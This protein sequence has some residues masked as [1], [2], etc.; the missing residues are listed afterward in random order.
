MNRFGTAERNSSRRVGLPRRVVWTVLASCAV[1]LLAFA[2]WGRG[3]KRHAPVAS[4]SAEEFFAG[5]S[6]PARSPASS[7]ALEQAQRRLLPY[8]VIPGGVESA[9][10]LKNAIANDPIVAAHYAGFNL[11]KARVQRLDRDRAV[12]VSYRLGNR[13]YWTSGKRMLFKGETV[14]TDGDHEART[15]CGN[16]ISETPA[17][18]VS[19]KEPAVEV[20]EFP[21]E[22]L[23]A[24]DLPPLDLP[25]AFPVTPAAPLPGPAVEEGFIPTSPILPVPVGFF[26]SSPRNPGGPGNSENPGNPVAPFYPL[27][28]SQQPP[29]STPEPDALLLAALGIATLLSGG[30]LASIRNRRERLLVSLP[31]R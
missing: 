1:M 5:Q 21:Q 9:A 25:L 8:S 31:R 27:P 29:V 10:E 30:W 2:I 28:S 11:A 12:Y 18:P 4:S 22:Q 16:R 6:V 7:S 23:V 13:V 20:M 15:R 17:Q 3:T 19:P 26:P 14:I 24:M